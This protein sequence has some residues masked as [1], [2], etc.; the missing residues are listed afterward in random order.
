MTVLTVDPFYVGMLIGL[1]VGFVIGGITMAVF[2][3]SARETPKP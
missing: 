3:A 1:F 2:A